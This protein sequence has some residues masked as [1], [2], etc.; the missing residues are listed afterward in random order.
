MEKEGKLWSVRYSIVRKRPSSSL[1]HHLA[2]PCP[3]GPVVSV[4]SVHH[5]TSCNLNLWETRMSKNDSHLCQ[6]I[7]GV[8]PVAGDHLRFLP[9]NTQPRNIPAY[10]VKWLQ[11]RAGGLCWSTFRPWINQTCYQTAYSQFIISVSITNYI[12]NIHI[13][14]CMKT[15][16]H[17]HIFSPSTEN[18]HIWIKARMIMFTF[19]E[20]MFVLFGWFILKPKCLPCK[21][22]RVQSW[23][24]TAL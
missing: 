13:H 19:E 15:C 22:C 21:K 17:K 6:D 20:L 9:S 10:T 12:S 18:I 16:F 23:E 5:L 8:W 2:R 3:L 24:F 7:L 1:R 14:I 4:S 11:S